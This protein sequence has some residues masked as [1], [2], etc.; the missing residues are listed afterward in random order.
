MN[1]FI[2]C[3]FYIIRCSITE[4]IKSNNNEIFNKY[5]NDNTLKHFK[6]KSVCGYVSKKN[7]NND[8]QFLKLNM[9]EEYSNIDSYKEN[10]I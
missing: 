9:T 5:F 7:L 8:N 2:N 1:I 6:N 3:Y 4:F 10:N